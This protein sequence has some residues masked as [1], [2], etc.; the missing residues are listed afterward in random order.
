VPFIGYLIIFNDH[1]IDYAKIARQLLSDGR[2]ATAE[3][4]NSMSLSNLYYL[5]LGLVLTGFGSLLFAVFCP[6]DIRQSGSLNEYIRRSE[7]I[8]SP[9]LVSD[10]LD[11]VMTAYNKGLEQ[12]Q[13]DD[14]ATINIRTYLTYPSRLSY[15]HYNL[16]HHIFEE[17]PDLYSSDERDASKTPA[18]QSEEHET[19]KSDSEYDPVAEFPFHQEH[20]GYLDVDS[21]S[22]LIVSR[23]GVLRHF[24][25][26]FRRYSSGYFKDICL[27]RFQILDHSTPYI[28]MTIAIFYLSGFILLFV[29][30]LKTLYLVL[31]ALMAA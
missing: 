21:V 11:D 9:T 23:P 26:E 27:L 4:Q 24:V 31:S 8:K 7:E 3:D 19:L 16:V 6:P 14:T 15:L 22:N 18:E 13:F 29:P 28:R 5:Y 20:T 1:L 25:K 10:H 2:V 30:T 12:V 17:H